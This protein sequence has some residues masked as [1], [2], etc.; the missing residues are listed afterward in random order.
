MNEIYKNRKKTTKVKTRSRNIKND[1]N[2]HLTTY[3]YNSND[4]IIANETY[5]T[6][7]NNLSKY[8]KNLKNIFFTNINNKKTIYD[9][10]FN[11]NQTISKINIELKNDIHNLAKNYND[12]IERNN[13]NLKGLNSYLEELKEDNFLLENSLK[14]K[15]FFIKIFSNEIAN[16]NPISE[17]YVLYSVKLR[18]CQIKELT[19]A[20]INLNQLSKETNRET[21]KSHRLKEEMDNLKNEKEKI[22]FNNLN[23]NLVKNEI[24]FSDFEKDESNSSITSDLFSEI[25]YNL[26]IDLNTINKVIK[27]S[28][29]E[30]IV[31]K[32]KEQIK[33]K[34][35]NLNLKNNVPKNSITNTKIPKLNLKQI[36][37]NMG[38]IIKEKNIEINDNNDELNKENEIFYKIKKIKKHIKKEKEKNKKLL[39]LIKKFEKFQKNYNKNNLDNNYDSLNNKINNNVNKIKV[40]KNYKNFNTN[41]ED[42]DTYPT[43]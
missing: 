21:L 17:K 36:E 16:I 12:K 35:L 39:K 13:N 4:L 7:I 30:N 34:N 26:D 9:K 2:N 8:I 29:I 31:K 28:N 41:K 40:I 22:K 38:N 10:I 24:Y 25:N 11:I 32:Q 43:S 20:Q 3:A 19:N 23:K 5:K 14:T 33:I 27:K 1:L 42:L 18:E 6:Q 37:F 15:D